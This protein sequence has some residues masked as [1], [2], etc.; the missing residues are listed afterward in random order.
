MTADLRDWNARL[1]APSPGGLVLG[2]NYSGMHDTA[3]ALVTPEG[4]VLAACALERITRVKQDGRPFTPLLAGIDWTKIATVAISTNEHFTVPA[5]AHSVLHP[6]PLPNPHDNYVSEHGPVF[7]KLLGE[8]PVPKRFVD[9][10]LSHAAS[11]FYTTGFEDATCLAYDAGTNNC[12]WFGGLYEADSKGIRA[13]DRFAASHYAK[14]TL[15]YSFVTALLGFSPNKHEG[16]ITGLAAYGKP[17]AVCRDALCEILTAKYDHLEELVEWFL[18]YSDSAPPMLVM[19]PA[20]L[21]RLGAKLADFPRENVA[22]TLQTLTEEH[23]LAILVR[24]KERGWLKER[25]C[26]AGGLFANV[27][28]NQRV[29]E[30]VREVFVAPPMTD[31]GTAVGAA[32]AVAWENRPYSGRTIVNVSWGPDYSS[33]EIEAA[34]RHFDLKYEKVAGAEESIAAELARGAIVGIFEGRMEFGPRA[35]GNRSILCEA[36]EIAINQHLNAM[37]QRTEFMPFAPATRL[38]DAA[39]C[40]LGVQGAESAAHFMTTTFECTE[41]TR[42]ESPAVVHRDGTARPQLVTRSSSPLLYAILSHY[43]ELTGIPSIINTSFNIHEEPIVCSP[44]DA[45]RGFLRSGIDMLYLQGGYVVRASANSLAALN[46]LYDSATEAKKDARNSALARIYSERVYS[47][48]AQLEEKE[49]QIQILAGAADER[50]RALEAADAEI[51]RLT[52]TSPE[53]MDRS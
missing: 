34:L 49:E 45:I 27:R 51:S 50:L 16:K 44:D 52:S 20:L 13:L 1:I 40:Y 6:V 47:L 3:M 5:D 29:H 10:Q 53:T 32:L 4:E 12:P 30:F 23:V 21:E 19:D 17:D 14:I 48:N 41:K 2:I 26:L 8:L 38:E 33:A 39:E 25:I 24:A 28:V 11:A 15:L 37:L 35:L 43:R 36:R 22:A 46:Y 18:A 42:T 7:L 31:D 9:H